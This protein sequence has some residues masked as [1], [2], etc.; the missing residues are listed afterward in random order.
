MYS[1]QTHSGSSNLAL[2][3]IFCANIQYLQFG[4]LSWHNMNQKRTKEFSPEVSSCGKASE[5]AFKRFWDTKTL[6]YSWNPQLSKHC[7]PLQWREVIEVTLEPKQRFVVWKPELFEPATATL[8]KLQQASEVWYCKGL[9]CWFRCMKIQTRR[10]AS[11][12][13]NSVPNSIYRYCQPE[14]ASHEELWHT[15]QHFCSRACRGSVQLCWFEFLWYSRWM[16]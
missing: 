11:L 1:R 5:K 12:C 6:H 4:P 9:R 3:I 14:Q 7:P 15:N 16:Y 8:A 13:T 10:G 2:R